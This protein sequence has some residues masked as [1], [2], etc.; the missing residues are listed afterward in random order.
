MCLEVYWYT[1]NI[2]KMTTKVC[3]KL[4]K[5]LTEIKFHCSIKFAGAKIELIFQILTVHHS[6]VF[7]MIYLIFSVIFTILFFYKFFI[8][9]V[10]PNF[11]PGPK[12]V[13]PIL[14]TSLEEAYRLFLGQDEIEKHKEYRKRYIVSTKK[15][16]KKLENLGKDLTL[17]FHYYFSDMEIYIP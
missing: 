16:Y 12:I 8:K 10:P 4:A 11:P 15:N 3:K 1:P 13:I 2:P 9:K 14:G 6:I 7:E 5:S 17:I